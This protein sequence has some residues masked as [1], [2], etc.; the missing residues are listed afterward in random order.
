MRDDTTLE[1]WLLTNI[2]LQGEY[3]EDFKVTIPLLPPSEIQLRFTGREGLRNLR[4]GFNFW[5]L[6]YL[7]INISTTT[8]VLDFGSGWGRIGRFWLIDLAPDNVYYADCLSEAVNIFKSLGYSSPI[9]HCSTL[10]PLKNRGPFD[11]IHAYSVFSHLNEPY[12]NAWLKEFS[13]VL[14]PG[15]KL[16]ITSRGKSFIQFVEKWQRNGKKESF[17]GHMLPE[18]SD[19]LDKYLAGEFQFYTE[20]GG[21]G[22]LS[23]E[24]Y[25]QAFVPEQYIRK[26]SAEY[27]YSEIFRMPTPEEVDQAVFMLVKEV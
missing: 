10:P 15:G 23:S 24:F 13:K 2:D 3:D 1:N 5:K 12:F 11:V 8:Q 9:E 18:A 16:F 17:N 14:K 25:G 19:L 21:G 4:Q 6:M 26:I 22:E 27:G 7:N 20:S